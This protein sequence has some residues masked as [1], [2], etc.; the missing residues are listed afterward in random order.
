MERKKWKIWTKENWKKAIEKELKR[1]QKEKKILKRWIYSKMNWKLKKNKQNKRKKNN[2][3]IRKY[4]KN[5]RKTFYIM[6][7]GKRMTKN[8]NKIWDIIGQIK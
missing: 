2:L 1:I 4:V 6:W 5:R 8:K 7:K 3:R